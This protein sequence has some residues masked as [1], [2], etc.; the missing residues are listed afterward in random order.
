[1]YTCPTSDGACALLLIAIWVEV[2][3]DYWAYVIFTAHS[4]F[5]VGIFHYTGKELW[6]RLKHE[7][8]KKGTVNWVL[9]LVT[10]VTACL[11]PIVYGYNAKVVG[12]PVRE[13]NVVEDALLVYACTL[14]LL[15]MFYISS[16]HHEHSVLE[17]HLTILSIWLQLGCIL[18]LTTWTSF[19][20][21]KQIN[22]K[23]H[24]IFGVDV[25][26]SLALFCYTGQEICMKCR[27]KPTNLKAVKR[28][29]GLCTLGTMLLICGVYYYNT[30]GLGQHIMQLNKVFWSTTVV[31][32]FSILLFCLVLRKNPMQEGAVPLSK[33]EDDD[34]EKG[35]ETDRKLS[36]VTVNVQDTEAI[37]EDTVKP[38]NI[39]HV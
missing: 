14:V 2:A 39:D 25:A 17:F 20:N 23:A 34:A 16:L 15:T 12:Q 38:N 21:D 26:F 36:Q 19:F 31:Y 37:M 28:V 33:T 9:V 18:V 32:I 3:V 1:M 29:C 4:L 10:F 5:A 24:I 30:L 6:A 8:I 7:P 27:R 22:M 11:F 35:N 13:S